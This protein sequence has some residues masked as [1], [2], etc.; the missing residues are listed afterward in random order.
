MNVSEPRFADGIGRG[1]DGHGR[2]DQLVEGQEARGKKREDWLEL[3]HVARILCSR[4]VGHDDVGKLN[5]RTAKEP[6][7]ASPRPEGSS[8]PTPS[9]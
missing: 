6:A 1:D 5:E 7:R 9:W 4:Y 3:E 2:L 8:L